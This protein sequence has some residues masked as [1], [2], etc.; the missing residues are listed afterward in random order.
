MR[1]FPDL[2][3]PQIDPSAFIADTARVFGEVSI[4]AGA[5]VWHGASIRAEVAPAT[6]GRKTNIQDNAVLHTD[7]GF[8]VSLGDDVTIG[9][10]AIVHGATVEDGAL[11]GMG[12]V[13]LNGSRVEAGAFVAA[14]CVVPPGGV[15]TAGMLAV[16][17]PMRILREVREAE[18]ASIANGL[19]HYS[20]Y[21][22]VYKSL[23]ESEE[24]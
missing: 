21:A 11:V 6:I 9:H 22:K 15:V 18:A 13:L 10:G 5:S 3:Q 7:D 17:N 24:R 16:G 20:H 12:A 2:K 23:Q 19:A 1:E 8:P 4:G 14:A